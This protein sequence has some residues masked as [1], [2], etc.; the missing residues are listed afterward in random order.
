MT[1]KWNLPQAM[2]NAGVFSPTELRRLL[3]TK[4]GFEI[5]GPAVHRLVKGLP[6]ECKLDTLD[7]LCQ[8]LNCGIS[9]ILVYERP[10]EANQCIQPL[11]LE[12]SFKPPVRIKKASR[13]INIK[14]D[15]PPI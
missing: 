1:L 14:I 3:K 8:S 13:E 5:S 4:V 15:I 11:V 2:Y 7:A 9:D 10:T 6:K 12:S